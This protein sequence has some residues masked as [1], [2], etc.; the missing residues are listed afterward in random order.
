MKILMVS[1]FSY[2]FVNWTLQLKES[3]HEVF[4]IDVHDSNTHVKRIDFVEQTIK[5]KNKLEYPGRQR[6]KK[7]FPLLG[8]FINRFNHRN[9][10]EVFQQK[11]DEI[12][13]DVV[14]SFEIHSA[15]IPILDIMKK[16]PKVKW[17]YSAL[18]SDLF[19]YQNEPAKLK[20]IKKVFTRLNY[21]FADSTRDF[22]IAQKHG[23]TG[24]Y[25]GTFP[26]GGGY[27]LDSVK[28]RI[29]LL[30]DRKSI[31]IKG[32]QNKFG[33]CNNVLESLLLIEN[34]IKNFKIIVFAANEEVSNLVKN[35]RFGQIKNLEIV[36][37]IGR[38]D[39]L[40]LMGQSLICIGNSISDGIPNTLL[41]AIIMEAFPIQ[42]NPGGS[43]AEI[44][45]NGKNG[46]LIENP[47]SIY[48]IAALIKKAIQNPELLRSG[49]AYNS[50]Y[51]K[52]NLER[53][54]IKEQVL[55]SYALVEANLNS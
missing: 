12:Q 49:I 15:C 35:P 7:Y 27:E 21:M 14:H 55:K 10:L 1:V 50:Q 19:Y 17:I 3:G 48:E 45:E 51:I 23:F 24:G 5:W 4:W 13:P 18:G 43:T 30:K 53:D 6:I 34:E 8:S 29:N 44:I 37:L 36:G 28:S 2:H 26:G 22:I 11:F 33:R 46:L 42:S 31:L 32:Y 9:F 47:E 52:S 38:D 20:G 25:L 39:V 54:Y 41:E 40:K 16:Y